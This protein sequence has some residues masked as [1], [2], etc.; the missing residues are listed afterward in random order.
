MGILVLQKGL[1]GTRILFLGVGR[2]RQNLSV[3][4]SRGIRAHGVGRLETRG[5]G[6]DGAKLA[7]SKGGRLGLRRAWTRIS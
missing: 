4:M 2:I 3:L 1:E 6:P 5:E 7:N